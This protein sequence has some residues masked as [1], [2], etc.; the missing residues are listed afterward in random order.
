MRCTLQLLG[1]SRKVEDSVSEHILAEEEQGFGTREIFKKY[2]SR[3]NEGKQ[4]YMK[5]INQL[6]SDGKKLV[7]Y[8]ASATS[9]TL[10]H[11][12]EM[13][14]TLDYLVDDFEA[15]QG[16]FSPGLHVPIYP[17]DEI[18]KSTPDYVVVLAWRYY[19]KIIKKHQR[20]LDQGGRFIIPLP[21][22]K[23]I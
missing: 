3:I 16:L 20:F 19:E 21:K 11:H 15:K 23:I 1:G 6:K 12:Y 9:T 5:L 17:S 4:E 2:S 18:Y 22:L 10:M 8:G 13:A 7:G 14:G